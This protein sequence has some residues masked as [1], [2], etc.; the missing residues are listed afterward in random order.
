[1]GARQNVPR[2]LQPVFREDGLQS[3]NRV[4]FHA[5]S[6]LVGDLNLTALRKVRADWNPVYG[7][8]NRYPAA[9]KRLGAGK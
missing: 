7:L 2:R 6:V 8:P 5:E 1:M 9:Y 4:P 3:R